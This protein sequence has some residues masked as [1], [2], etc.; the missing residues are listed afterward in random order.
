[1]VKKRKAKVVE[2]EVVEGKGKKA[3]VEVE[4]K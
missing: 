1:L 4:E 3:K 2:E